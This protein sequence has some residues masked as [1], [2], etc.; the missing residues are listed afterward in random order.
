MTTN[1]TPEQALDAAVE[2]IGPKVM[3]LVEITQ[4]H[5]DQPRDHR[6]QTCS[7]CDSYILHL[8]EAIRTELEQAYA[9][10]RRDALEEAPCL[11]VTRHQFYERGFS[12]IAANIDYDRL[13]V[14]CKL[15]TDALATPTE[16]KP[17]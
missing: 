12:C 1:Q 2:R 8:R 14:R 5:G 6:S 10:G 16:T 13:C 9:A 7:M 4:Q 3:T 11:D 15:L 17:T